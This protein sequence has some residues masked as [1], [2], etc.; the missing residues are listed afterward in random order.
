MAFEIEN[1]SKKKSLLFGIVTY[2]E[3]PK[4]TVVKPDK[5]TEPNKEVPNK[6]VQDKTPDVKRKPDIKTGIQNI[7]KNPTSLIILT[8]LL[9]ASIIGFFKVKKK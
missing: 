8:G 2:K 4:E 1:P 9:L 6:E 3:K 7:K 5:P